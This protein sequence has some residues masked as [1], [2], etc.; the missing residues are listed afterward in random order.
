MNDDMFKRALFNAMQNNHSDD[1]DNNEE[2]CVSSIKDANVL[3]KLHMDPNSASYRKRLVEYVTNPEN[4]VFSEP[5]VY[6]NFVMDLFRAGDYDAAIKVC[7]FVLEYAPKNTDM[8]ADAIKACGDSSQF[9]RGETYLLKANEL[10]DGY[11]YWSWRLFL[12]A[13]D[14]LHTK[15]KAYP[16]DA[17][18]FNRAYDL[19]K[20]YVEKFPKDEHGYNQQA[21]ILITV[22]RQED[23]MADLY[24]F[25][26]DRNGDSTLI[27]AQCCV[28]LL[29]L[30][31]DSNDYKRIIEICDKGMCNTAQEQPSAALG[32][33]VYRKALALDAM[34]HNDGFREGTVK[35]AMKYYQAAYDLNQGRSYTE[36]IEQRYALLRIHMDPA[37]FVPLVKRSLFVNED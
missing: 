33:F 17:G 37:K 19:A 23:A 35:D 13:V 28:T 36:V 16:D 7:D 18:L 1:T 32:F 14:F 25:I 22:N 10:G 24:R 11:K 34:A 8:L 12:Y 21:E 6:H 15:L 30:L 20:K 5:D 2:M 9:D 31:D 4:R 27:C 3:L 26:T 29:N